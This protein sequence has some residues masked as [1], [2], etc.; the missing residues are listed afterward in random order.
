MDEVRAIFNRP[1]KFKGVKEIHEQIGQDITILYKV[2]IYLVMELNYTR[3]E[4]VYAYD[5]ICRLF[6]RFKKDYSQLGIFLGVRN[7]TIFYF[8][9]T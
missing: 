6:Q 9:L 8:E 7:P 4:F 5:F 1:L 2:L 3:S